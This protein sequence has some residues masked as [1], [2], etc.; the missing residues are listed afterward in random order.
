MNLLDDGSFRPARG[1]DAIVPDEFGVYAIRL[2]SGA[3]LP[4]PFQSFLDDRATRVIYV[5]QAS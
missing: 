2:R 3:V 5:G 1:I 4:E